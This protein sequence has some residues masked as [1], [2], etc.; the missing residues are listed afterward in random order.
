MHQK[1]VPDIFFILVNNPSSHGMQE[2]LLKIEEYQKDF[3]KLILLFLPKPIPFNG[4][5]YMKNKR[6]WS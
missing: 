1:L 5:D 3:K 2:I 4:K 6:A